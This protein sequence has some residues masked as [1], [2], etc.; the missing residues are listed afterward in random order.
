MRTSRKTDF[1]SRDI[2]K[3]NFSG[4]D[5]TQGLDLEPPSLSRYFLLMYIVPS[6]FVFKNILI[7]NISGIVTLITARLTRNQHDV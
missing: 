7:I 5:I 4:I 6:L 3:N 1:R 2:A